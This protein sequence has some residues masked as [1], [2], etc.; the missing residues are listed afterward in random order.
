MN[1]S[2]K[3]KMAIGALAALV[4]L[5]GT[6]WGG[7]LYGQSKNKFGQFPGQNQGVS[8]RANRQGGAG[9]N[10]GEILSKDDKSITIKLPTGGSKIILFSSATEIGKF[11]TGILDDLQ[12]GKNVMVQGQTNQDG[13]ITAQSIQIRPAGQIPGQ[14]TPPQ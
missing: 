10:S 14:K 11:T 6:F 8:I 13:S 4:V 7:M 5:A 2:H 9:F 1:K 3:I 12:V